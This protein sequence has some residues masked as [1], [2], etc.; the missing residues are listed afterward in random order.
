MSHFILGIHFCTANGLNYVTKLKGAI[1]KIIQTT[2]FWRK[3]S[4]RASPSTACG[5]S[6]W[7]Q[8]EN[9]EKK[10]DKMSARGAYAR[11]VSRSQGKSICSSPVTADQVGTWWTTCKVSTIPTCTVSCL[12]LSYHALGLHHQ[13]DS[14]C[15][16]VGAYWLLCC[17]WETFL[18]AKE[19]GNTMLFI[20][21]LALF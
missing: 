16:I 8:K 12:S 6:G 21:S 2:K 5:K 9:H 19:S 15:N 20:V 10:D 13:W 1:N 11:T 14:A 3:S 18:A 17:R 7:Y 4:T